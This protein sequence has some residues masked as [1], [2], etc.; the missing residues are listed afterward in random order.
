MTG[1]PGSERTAE[2]RRYHAQSDDDV[3]TSV[4]PVA[5]IWPETNGLAKVRSSFSKTMHGPDAT[6]RHQTATPAKSTE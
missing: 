3:I 6:K 1:P 5:P 2:G 4:S